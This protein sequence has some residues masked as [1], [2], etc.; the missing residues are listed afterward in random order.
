MSRACHP[1]K[2][3]ISP[4]IWLGLGLTLVALYLPPYAMAQE[5]VETAPGGGKPYSTQAKLLQYCKRR[6]KNLRSTSSP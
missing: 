5:S 2:V 4:L 1:E 3:S 6:T